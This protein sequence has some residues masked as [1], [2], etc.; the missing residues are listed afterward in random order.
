MVDG[1]GRPAAVWRLVVSPPAPGAWAMAIDEALLD[2]CVAAPAG[3]VPVLRLYA[4]APPCLSLGR[5]QR[6]DD[7]DRDACRRLNVDVVRRPSGGRAVLHDRCLTYALIAPAEAAPF[8]G[9]IRNSAE[10]I[11]AAL[12]AGL[13]RLGVV[14]STA[15]S[16]ERGRYPAD[17]FALPAAGEVVAGGRKLA[18][19]AQ[20]RRG[21]AALQHGSVRLRLGA[22]NAARLLRHSRSDDPSDGPTTLEALC[23]RPVTFTETASAVAAGIVGTFGVTLRGTVLTEAERQRAIE[24]ER[25]RYHSDGWT[26]GR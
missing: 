5:F 19:S 21:A 13:C 1:A 16:P 17:C 6:T 25:D 26:W 23:G 2:A 14:L 7:V 11:G 15:P 9:G 24:L 18:G 12:A 22:G 4:F 8:D 20:V 10:R 3:F